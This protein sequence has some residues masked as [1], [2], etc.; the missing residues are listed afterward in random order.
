[1]GVLDVT[2]I[3]QNLH[4]YTT[5]TSIGKDWNLTGCAPEEEEE[6]TSFQPHQAD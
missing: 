6:I 5:Y 4:G 1:V 3:T 2:S